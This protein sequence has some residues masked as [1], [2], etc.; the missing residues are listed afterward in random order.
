MDCLAGRICN[1]IYIISGCSGSRNG[2]YGFV[3]LY[4]WI[5]LAFKDNTKKEDNLESEDCLEYKRLLN[6]DIHEN[7]KIKKIQMKLQMI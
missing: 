2:H 7:K 6:K 3:L 1:N 4:G 5:H